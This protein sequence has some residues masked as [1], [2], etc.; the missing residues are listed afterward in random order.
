MCR[1]GAL[2]S[3]CADR[4]VK[5]CGARLIGSETDNL[6]MP[7]SAVQQVLPEPAA[8][9]SHSPL[10]SHVKVTQ[11]SGRGARHVGIAGNASDRNELVVNEGANEDLARRREQLLSAPD[12][13]SQTIQECEALRARLVEN[14][15]SQQALRLN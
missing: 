9:S 12:T 13:F 5:C 3:L 11:A 6:V 7:P 15:V 10:R 14:R 2:A 1:I 4:F 8:N